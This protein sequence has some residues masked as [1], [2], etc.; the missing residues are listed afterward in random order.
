MN[1]R[2]HVSPLSKLKDIFKIIP[3][4]NKIVINDV[5][6][7][8]KPV[9]EVYQIGQ[10]FTWIYFMWKYDVVKMTQPIVAC[11]SSGAVSEI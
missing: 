4:Y 5:L 10:H 1:S 3:L 7:M 11:Q 6:I 8:V 9:M 2:P